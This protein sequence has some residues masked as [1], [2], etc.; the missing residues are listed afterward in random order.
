[1]IA[2]PIAAV[3][4]LYL[5]VPHALAWRILLGLGALPAASVIYLRRMIKETPH[6]SLSAAGD[7]EAAAH[8]VKDITGTLIPVKKNGKSF[9]LKTKVSDLFR[10]PNNIRLLGTA[11]SWFL[12]DWAFYGNSISWPLVMKSFLP[13]ATFL[14]GLMASAAVFVIFAA[15]F[16][17]VAAFN[18][19]KLGRKTIQT[20]GFV[21]M[22]LAYLVISLTSWFGFALAAI[23]FLFVFGL[24]YVFTEF[25]PNTTTFVYPSEVFPTPLRGFGDGISA[26]FGKIG[27]F[28]GT[29]L[30]PFLLAEAKIP[31]T[32]AILASI[33]ILGAFLTLTCLPEPKNVSLAEVS[34]ENQYL[35]DSHSTQASF[36]MVS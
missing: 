25:G 33:S 12:L 14:Q 10:Y 5:G 7:P 9:K 36:E 16:Y 19:D 31:G 2:G 23:P 20:L 8:A 17:F 27:A 6:F 29:F 21:G 18:M 13:H 26:G 28:I 30:F 11:G 24:S 32:F 35:E 1:M 22:A 15:P 4:I 3:L 34:E